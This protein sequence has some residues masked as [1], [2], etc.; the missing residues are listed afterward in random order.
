MFIVLIKDTLLSIS[1]IDMCINQFAKNSENIIT[2]KGLHSHCNETLLAI[3]FYYSI[4]SNWSKTRRI[5]WTLGCVVGRY[6][7]K[8]RRIFRWILLIKY[9]FSNWWIT[10]KLILK[11]KILLIS[12]KYATLKKKRRKEENI[13]KIYGNFEIDAWFCRCRYDKTLD[14][15]IFVSNS[16]L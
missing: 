13:E 11:S 8:F 3:P 2:W 6:R 1:T 16:S 7:I 15:N 5:S 10:R 9:D 4:K 14:Y 12:L